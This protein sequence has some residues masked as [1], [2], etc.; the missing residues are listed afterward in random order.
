[1][2]T[3][4]SRP[5]FDAPA[6]Q[7]LLGR[8][9]IAT[10]VASVVLSAPPRYS[11]RVG[12]YGAWGTGKTSVLRF[13]R[14][15][16]ER[17]GHL[18]VQFS[19]WGYTDGRPMWQALAA[20]LVDVL[21]RAGVEVKGRWKTSAPFQKALGVGR[22]LADAKSA[23][24][25]IG[26]AVDPLLTQFLTFT[27]DELRAA[28]DSLGNRRVVVL[29][30]DLDRAD[31]KV[32]PH[33]LFALREVLDLPGLSWVLAMDPEIV[34]RTLAAYHPG[35]ADDQGDYL[36]KIAEFQFWLPEPSPDEVWRVVAHDL[37]T[38]VVS[39]GIDRGILRQELPLLP[40]NPRAL[41]AFLR[42]LAALTPEI[43]RYGADELDERL[44]VLVALLRVEFPKL[45]SHVAA[46][47]ELVGDLSAA[48]IASDRTDRDGRQR[49]ALRTKILRATEEFVVE[50]ERP[51]AARV[52]ERLGSHDFWTPDRFRHHLGLLDRPPILTRQE[53][54]ACTA[55]TDARALQSWAEQW[56]GERTCRLQDVIAAAWGRA[57]EVHETLMQEAADAPTHEEMVAAVN[58][59]AEVLRVLEWLSVDLGGFVG[60]RP[61]LSP[62]HFASIIASVSR[63]AHFDNTTEYQELR[64]A[65]RELILRIARDASIDPVD[66]LS[67]LAPWDTDRF[68]SGPPGH[69]DRKQ[70]RLDVTK[71]VE[72]K[73]AARMPD[74]FKQPSGI[75]ALLAIAE[76]SAARYL[77]FRAGSPL[78]QDGLRDVM[79]QAL[80]SDEPPVTDNATDF[81]RRVVSGNSFRE[82][83]DR[84]LQGLAADHELMRW[85]WAACVRRR[86]NI[87]RCVSIRNLHAELEQQLQSPLETP[88]WWSDVEE[89]LRRLGISD[90]PVKPRRTG[91][92]IG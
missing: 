87:R 1:M 66:M 11:V 83:S 69:R 49:E 37:D 90:E 45:A 72:E 54:A 12:V 9:P 40:R 24:K 89:Q 58:R 48:C 65:E 32:V 67:S 77:V 46:N 82:I 3:S 53:F 91:P 30:D 41:R 85:C 38:A 10:A 88:R 39:I 31:P 20:A 35:F 71:A 15:I 17:D 84:E 23:S 43:R 13:V 50:H 44:L 8:W 52:L 75:N 29:V 27:T 61:A 80:E 5:G 56:A 63:W 57:V 26:A 59:C 25:A 51:I 92:S 22:K 14:Q 86:P 16:A 81:V 55:A 21:V 76:E 7:D 73:A 68:D 70:L 47:E 18:V 19:P 79:R 6:E 74:R 36:E 34:T 62:Q 28:T 64:R 60:T 33:V 78:W 2:P 4:A 42:H